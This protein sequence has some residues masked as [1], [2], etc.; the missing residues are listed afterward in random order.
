MNLGLQD[1]CF[2]GL[3]DRFAAAFGSRIQET[4]ADRRRQKRRREEKNERG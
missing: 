1:L 2:F 3:P 4:V